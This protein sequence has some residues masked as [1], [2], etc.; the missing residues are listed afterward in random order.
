MS[1]THLLSHFAKE[2]LTLVGMP[3]RD[4][5]IQDP[6]PPVGILLTL[7]VSNET[8]IFS[9]RSLLPPDRALLGIWFSPKRPHAW[10]AV[11]AWRCGMDEYSGT[12]RSLFYAPLFC[13]E[14]WFRCSIFNSSSI[15]LN[16]IS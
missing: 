15:C 7:R 11:E 9:S 16:E 13:M 1:L 14:G 8:I 10:F 2:N 6:P 4:A 5:V 12:D 3:S